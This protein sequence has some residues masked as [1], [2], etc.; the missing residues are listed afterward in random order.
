[1]KLAKY[2][3]ACRAVAEA[4]TVDEAKD[5]RDKAEAMRAYARQAK[6][7]QLEVDTAEI[8]M[9][10]ERRLGEIIKLQKETVGLNT[11]TAGKGRPNL[12][13]SDEVPPKNERPT[14][15]EVGIDKK[16]SMRAQ[17]LA[18]VPEGKFEGMLGEW[19]ERVSEE[20]TR[21]TTN[22][23]REGERATR[24]DELKTVK[25]EWPEGK[26]AVFYADPPWRYEH[27]PIGSSSRSIENHYTTMT[28]EEIC[29]LP[30]EKVSTEGAILYLWATA[31]KLAECLEVIK[32][33]GFE[34]RTC[35]V[36]VKDRI[37]MGY[38]AR[39]Q[40]EILLVAKRGQ[41]PPPPVEVRVSSVVEARRTAHRA[42]PEKFHEFIEA[43]YPDAPK[44]ELFARNQR[45]GW[46][47][48]GNQ[49]GGK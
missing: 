12:G 28:L 36:W 40:H 35:F 19:R 1:M 10:A 4:K 17:K 39:N 20:T 38:H 49:A 45:D 25:T 23:L 22:L 26:Y 24:D 13:G 42:K 41:F 43:F 48:W 9:R 8:R 5:L 34:Y 44:L 16:L 3:A 32:A 27:P 21:V 46:S 6:N 14:L 15:A 33:W 31:P 7:R 11:G 37:G 47:V 29:A 30:V 2:D 18:A